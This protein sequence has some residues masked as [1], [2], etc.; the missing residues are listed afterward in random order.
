METKELKELLIKKIEMA[1][2]AELLQLESF[3]NSLE[4]DGN[5]Y[6]NT[7]PALKEALQKSIEQ[8]DRGEVIPHEEVMRETRAKYGFKKT[9]AANPP[10]E[11]KDLLEIAQKQAKNGQTR[12]NDE[13]KKL[14]NDKY[15]LQ[16]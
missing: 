4:N 15:G 3:I 8:A 10:Q 2:E 7:S 9:D 13:V 14:I 11:I 6:K 5:W 12:S 16:L 1:N